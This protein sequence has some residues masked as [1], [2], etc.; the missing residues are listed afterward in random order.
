[1]AH[2]SQCLSRG[3]DVSSSRNVEGHREAA[4]RNL[5]PPSARRQLE[6][7][8]VQTRANG[9][10]CFAGSRENTLENLSVT[11]SLAELDN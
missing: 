11:L 3:N 8:Y 10:S 6:E 7:I 9:F 4:P 5:F 2:D 1:M